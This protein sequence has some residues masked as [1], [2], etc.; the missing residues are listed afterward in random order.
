MQSSLDEQW[1]S[2]HGASKASSSLDMGAKNGN[3]ELE[4]LAAMHVPGAIQ[5]QIAMALRA[6]DYH[7]A[8]DALHRFVLEVQQRVC[9]IF[10]WCIRCHIL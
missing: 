2:S 3:C 7:A 1:Q 5:L 8:L 4:L 10:K 6:H 9:L